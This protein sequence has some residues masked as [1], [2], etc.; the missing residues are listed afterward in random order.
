MKNNPYLKVKENA[1]YTATPEELTLMLYEG[2]LKFANQALIMLEK[3]DFQE[4]NRLIQRV[5]DIIREFQ[6]TL[7]MKY[8]ISEQL[9]QLYEYIYRRLTEANIKKDKEIL[10]EVIS[11]L[12]KLR[13]TWKQTIKLAKTK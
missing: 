1:I 12:R 2:A 3:K 4:T 9:F 7:N 8:E 6:T 10:T 11:H 13:D 5:K